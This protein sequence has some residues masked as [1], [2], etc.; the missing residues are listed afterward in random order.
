[1]A[2]TLLSIRSFTF[3]APNPSP[4]IPSR[5]KDRLIEQWLVYNATIAPQRAVLARG[6]LTLYP[7]Q[8][9]QRNHLLTKRFVSIRQ[10]CNW[11]FHINPL[12][13]AGRGSEWHNVWLHGA[14]PPSGERWKTFQLAGGAELQKYS[15]SLKQSRTNEKGCFMTSVNSV[16]WRTWFCTLDLLW[17]NSCLIGVPSTFLRSIHSP[18][19]QRDMMQE[20]L[21]TKCVSVTHRG[22]F[23]SISA[24]YN[25]YHLHHKDSSSSWQWLIATFSSEENNAGRTIRGFLKNVISFD[26]PVFQCSDI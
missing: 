25:L 23:D 14:F 19:H 17:W 6:N 7:W 8:S 24:F 9:M 16:D 5:S 12:V 10:Q 3:A 1:M 26:W 20:W 2:P 11:T 22:F 15:G 4:L 21:V 13:A 18:H